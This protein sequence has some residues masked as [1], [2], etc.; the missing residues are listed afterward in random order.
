MRRTLLLVLL[1]G[2]VLHASGQGM[3]G[4]DGADTA[5]LAQVEPFPASGPFREVKA[6]V[7]VQDEE[8]FGGDGLLGPG[9]ETG[10]GGDSDTGGGG[11]SSEDRSW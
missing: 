7:F 5:V 11:A 8:W 1:S 6:N 9:C 3:Q 4:A 2:L 10:F